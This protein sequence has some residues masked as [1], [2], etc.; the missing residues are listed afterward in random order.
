MKNIKNI[1]KGATPNVAKDMNGATVEVG[2]FVQA[3]T[4][5]SLKN[6][7][8]V[9]IS[10]EV[11]EVEDVS[12]GNILITTAL[13]KNRWLGAW[14]VTVVSSAVANEED[15]TDEELFLRAIG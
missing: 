7:E 4:D 1:K 14:G 2:M 10:G 8:V 3:Q 11:Y 9:T 6:G 13:G 12:R 15:L 5:Y